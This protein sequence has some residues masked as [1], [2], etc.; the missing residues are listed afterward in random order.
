MAKK[1]I[2][3]FLTT[4][5]LLSAQLFAAECGKVSEGYTA[6]STLEEHRFMV[7]RDLLDYFDHF[8]PKFI[9]ALLKLRGK[10]RWVDL[11][12]GESF[13]A[14]MYLF[15]KEQAAQIKTSAN[16]QRKSA[17]R[18]LTESGFFERPLLERAEVTV[19]SYQ[20]QRE[21]GTFN[22][23]LKVL[24]DRYFEAIADKDIPAFDFATDVHGIG[25]YTYHPER[26][27]QRVIAK[28]KEGGSFFVNSYVFF[29]KVILKSGESVHFAHFLSQIPG[30]KVERDP[31]WTH[32]TITRDPAVK[33]V[34]IPKLKV[35][36]EKDG[37]PPRRI[38]RVVD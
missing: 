33:K 15:G 29:N 35:E 11:G 10:D 38:F 14:E 7:R 21:L 27:F 9:E 2:C 32:I 8:S 20:I 13:A 17:L 30:I 16:P 4:L 18:R 22:G 28:M 5:F 37:F 34:V 3:L 12:S 24:K 19:I 36:S 23:R 1:S 26:Y 6:S 31:Y 25:A